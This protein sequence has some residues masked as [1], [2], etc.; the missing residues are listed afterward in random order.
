MEEVEEV[1][2]VEELEEETAGELLA[3][4]VPSTR[5]VRGPTPMP[6]KVETIR[7]RAAYIKLI[8]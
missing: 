2:E 5:D 4:L 8:N 1:E 6:P 7:L 3:E